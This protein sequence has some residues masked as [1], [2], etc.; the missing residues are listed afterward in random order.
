ME[1]TDMGIIKGASFGFAPIISRK[2]EMKGKTVRELKEVY[3]G[4]TSLIHTLTPINPKAGV[5]SVTKAEEEWVLELKAHLETME[6]F[7]R[8]SKASDEC[9][10]LIEQE[11]KAAQTLIS[12]YDTA[13]T[14]DEEPDVSVD[15]NGVATYADK[16][17]VRGR[18]RQLVDDDNDP[19]NEPDDDGDEL[20]QRLAL[21]N[22]NI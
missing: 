11:L 4:E 13:Y 10:K 21:L 16:V 9:I 19:E 17:A 15:G 1:M 7:C 22:A 2:T 20:L 12:Q 18:R 6:K 14:P 5:V 3:H 8:S